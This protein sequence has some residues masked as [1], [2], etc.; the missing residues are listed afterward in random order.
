MRFAAQVS[1]NTTFIGNG[2]GKTF[3]VLSKVKTHGEKVF[4]YLEEV[5]RVDRD[6]FEMQRKV[7]KFVEISICKSIKRSNNKK[8]AR[9]C[10]F[11]NNHT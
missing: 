6:G 8:D 7:V 10:I 2:D 1:N 11:K 4:W 5:W 3:A 9:I